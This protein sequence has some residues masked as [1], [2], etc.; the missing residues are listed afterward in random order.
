MCYPS[1]GNRDYPY[2]YWNRLRPEVC[3]DSLLD[4]ALYYNYICRDLRNA[5]NW[6]PKDTDSIPVYRLLQIH[7]EA[8]EDNQKPESPNG[9]NFDD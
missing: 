1:I 3:W 5:Y 6:S 9:M 2:F 8:L 7:E 4:L